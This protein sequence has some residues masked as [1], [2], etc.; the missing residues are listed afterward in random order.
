[1]DFDA[2]SL[3]PSAMWDEN[4]VFLKMEPGFAFKPH[5]NDLY[6]EAFNIQSFNQDVKVNFWK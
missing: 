4:T 1:M 3:Y 6:V 5:L 2:P